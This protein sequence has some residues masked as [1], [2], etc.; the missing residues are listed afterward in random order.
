[1]SSTGSS[2]QP[3]FYFDPDVRWTPLRPDYCS[4]KWELR[5]NLD[6]LADSSEKIKEV[7]YY[8]HP[9]NW[10][11][12]QKV[13]PASRVHRPG[14]GQLVLVHREGRRRH[15]HPAIQAPGRCSRPVSQTRPY[16]Q[17]SHRDQL[18]AARPQRWYRD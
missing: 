5:E 14:H 13:C 12:M 2:V 10:W 17:H 6:N 1:M 11:Q 15:H 8:T 4:T 7:M 18:G 16:H 3:L 9:L